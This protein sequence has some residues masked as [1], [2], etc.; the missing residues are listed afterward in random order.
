M[1]KVAKDVTIDHAGGLGTFTIDGEPFPWYVLR[2]NL[3]VTIAADGESL[4]TITVTIPFD[5]NFREWAK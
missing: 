4:S 3:D 5:G 2:Q 1:T